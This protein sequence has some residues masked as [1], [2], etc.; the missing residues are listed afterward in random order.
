[1]RL[2]IPPPISELGILAGPNGGTFIVVSLD[3]MWMWVRKI[4]MNEIYEKMSNFL[5]NII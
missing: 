2:L 1:V 4:G 5:V 3:Y